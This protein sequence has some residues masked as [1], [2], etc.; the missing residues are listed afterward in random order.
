MNRRTERS[1]ERA[2]FDLVEV[3]S[4]QICAGGTPVFPSLWIRVVPVDPTPAR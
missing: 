2:G 4:F 1:L 3:E